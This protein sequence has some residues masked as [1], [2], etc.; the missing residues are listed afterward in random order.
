MNNELKSKEIKIIKEVFDE[1]R[2]IINY[3]PKKMISINDKHYQGG[4]IFITD[5]G[6]L[7]DLEIQLE[8]FNE[9]ELYKYVKLAEELYEINN[10]EISIYILCSKQIKV[11]APE[12]IINSKAEFTIKLACFNEN[13]VNELFIQIKDKI[14]RKI[15]LNKEDLTTLAMIPYMVPEKDRDRMLIECYE[16]LSKSQI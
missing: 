13:P 10:V 4:D 9:T 7:I 1:K 6:E 15:S 14:N 3:A 11:I 8:D 2:E 5:T 12:Q 16:L